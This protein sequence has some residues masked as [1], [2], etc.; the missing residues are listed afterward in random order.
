MEEEAGV[1]QGSG[2][3]RGLTDPTTAPATTIRPKLSGTLSLFPAVPQPR[4]PTA[5]ANLTLRA[6]QAND[7]HNTV[8]SPR[9]RSI[10]LDETTRPAS[11]PASKP[12]YG[13]YP[14]RAV[15]K[16]R[17]SSVN[18]IHPMSTLHELALLDSPTVP[19]RFTFRS[20]VTTLNSDDSGHG[21][22]SSAPSEYE[23]SPLSATQEK[24]PAWASRQATASSKTLH[25]LGLTWPSPAVPVSTPPFSPSPLSAREV[26]PMRAPDRPASRQGNRQKPNL[27]INVRREER[28]D[29][30][31][32]PPPKS[33]RHH[34]NTSS[35]HSK[36]PSVHSRASSVQSRFSSRGSSRPASPIAVA[37]PVVYSFVKPTFVQHSNQSKD[38]L[39]PREGSVRSTAT[40]ETRNP[41]TTVSADSDRGR[42][43]VKAVPP[44]PT[45]VPQL[46]ELGTAESTSPGLSSLLSKFNIRS[47]R[48]E[49]AADGE[50]TP[51]PHPEQPKR[52]A[53]IETASQSSAS[54][55][56]VRKQRSH[57]AEPETSSLSTTSLRSVQKLTSPI[58]DP[59]IIARSERRVDSPQKA[60]LHVAK[61]EVPPPT[62]RKDTF[63]SRKAVPVA[64]TQAITEPAQRDATKVPGSTQGPNQAKVRMQ[65]ETQSSPPPP[66]RE[67]PRKPS[68]PKALP[69]QLRIH[70]DNRKHTLTEDRGISPAPGSISRL[71]TDRPT[72]ELPY[73]SATPEVTAESPEDPRETLRKLALQTEAL[74]ARYSTLRS[75]RQKLSTSIVASLRD[76]RSGPEYANTL[77]DQHLS[78]AAVNS[79]MDI[80]FAKL[81]SLDCRK[82]EAMTAI[83]A[84]HDERRRRSRIRQLDSPKSLLSEQLTPDLRGEQVQKRRSASRLRQEDSGPDSKHDSKDS[85]DFGKEKLSTRPRIGEQYAR[86][87]KASKHD[88]PRSGPRSPMLRTS[89]S[90]AEVLST[91]AHPSK[92]SRAG[93]AQVVKVLNV[94][95]T[96]APRSRRPTD[97][98]TVDRQ[99]LPTSTTAATTALAL[100]PLTIKTSTNNLRLPLPPRSPAPTSPLPSPPNSRSPTPPTTLKETINA[101]GDASTHDNA[102]TARCRQADSNTSTRSE[103]HSRAGSSSATDDTEAATPQDE[104][105]TGGDLH[106]V[107]PLSDH[108]L[109]KQSMEGVHMYID[110][111]FLD[112]YHE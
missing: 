70:V 37:Q 84:R 19:S 86:G 67:P 89:D 26:S 20:G 27:R 76:Q 95:T 21:R 109:G 102:D 47:P 22:S 9:R 80:C 90:G 65:A 52:I 66:S 81:K 108:T 106:D 31:P 112:Y 34:A 75:D 105:P 45:S 99:M 42:A 39:V 29:R 41:T 111:D 58:A 85:S 8:E 60:H 14:P 23:V 77:L 72:P 35:S 100:K 18:E 101:R 56:S 25:G 46:P 55:D 54:L 93:A 69:A 30:P 36:G 48:E 40:T 91:D 57:I 83:L 12:K 94:T 49:P 97:P 5:A 3:D 96:N 17:K 51:R 44:A 71:R 88:H 2:N 59:G 87:V 33:P 92:E 11:L 62:P 50:K 64:S 1:P 28:P 107:S 63:I 16:G 82:E 6:R 61:Q 38:S 15:R 74:H 7:H 53:N 73:R 103:A 68:S 10:S 43:I 104:K 24:L 110:D 79:S 98:S 4:P 13:L 32:P 78:L